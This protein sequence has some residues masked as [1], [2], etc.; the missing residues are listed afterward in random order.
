MSMQF[1]IVSL[2]PEI[3]E[4]LHHG[5][6]GRAIKQHIIECKFSNP[7]SFGL[8]KHAVVDD[9]PYG[10]GAGMVMRPEPLIAAIDDCQRQLSHPPL[11]IYL[12][13][14]GQSINQAVIEELASKPSLLLVCGRYEG[15]DQ[16][17]IKLAIDIEY[18]VGDF[19][20]SG[21]EFAACALIDAVTRLQ[22]NALGDK[23][24]LLDESF[25]NG[26]L[27]YPQYTRPKNYHGEKIPHTLLSGNHAI[28][29]EWRLQQALG[30]TWLKRPDLLSK[31]QLSEL[32]TD[33]LQA[34]KDH[35]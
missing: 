21:G 5:I 2:F 6:V 8:G 14:Q 22:P 24:S 12:S 16:R 17:V 28:I 23:K 3:F 30:N 19:I 4:S 35:L 18:S 31:R 13:P 26:L 15:I 25:S 10:G 11:K 34:F 27:E 33:L 20:L 7:R 1:G 29:A 9:K 32:E